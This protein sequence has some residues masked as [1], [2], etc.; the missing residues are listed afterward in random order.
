MNKF[1]ELMCVYIVRMT[2]SD[3]LKEAQ[4]RYRASHREQLREYKRVQSKIFYE[5]HKEEINAKRREK[6]R[7][8]RDGHKI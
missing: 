4:K 8:S 2:R 3:A 7:Q 6:Y 5:R 1:K